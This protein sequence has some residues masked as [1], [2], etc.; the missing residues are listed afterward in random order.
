M[1]IGKSGIP[2]LKKGYPTMSDKYN[3]IGGTLVGNEKVE[4]GQLVKHSDTAGYYEA[5]KGNTNLAG[6]VLATNVKVADWNE[7]IAYTYPG[8]AFNLLLNGYIAVELK[9]DVTEANIKANAKVYVTDA[10]EITTEESSN[11]ELEGCVFTGVHEK[12]GK[13]IIAEIL[14]K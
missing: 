3:V 11:K 10:G 14:V 5:A 8:E 9:S 13:K 7:D 1:I 6:F 2:M 12:H 4:F